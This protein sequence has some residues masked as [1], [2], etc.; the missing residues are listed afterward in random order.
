M[1]VVLLDFDPPQAAATAGTIRS[2]R[3]RRTS[4][5]GSA[6]RVERVLGECRENL[7]Q[8]G[9]PSLA[10]L[11]EDECIVDEDVELALVAADHLGA[12]FR[13]VDLGHETRGPLVVA[14]SD[15]AVQDADVC[16]AAEISDVATR[17]A[18]AQLL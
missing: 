9:P 18:P 8:L 16:H 12:V 4:A 2:K 5:E 15:G 13:P 10:L 17:R 6:A 3:A 14:V 1:V 7:G 11:G